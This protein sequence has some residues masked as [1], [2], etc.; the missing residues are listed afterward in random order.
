MGQGLNAPVRVAD[1]LFP[2]P[3]FNSDNRKDDYE[4]D[5]IL[6]DCCFIA[7]GGFRLRFRSGTA[8]DA[9]VPAEHLADGSARLLLRLG[10]RFRS[11]RHRIDRRGSAD[12]NLS[13][14]GRHAS[15]R[16]ARPH[17]SE[18]LFRRRRESRR[19]GRER[20][21]RRGGERNLQ[22]DGDGFRVRRRRRRSRFRQ[23]RRGEHQAESFRRHG[24]FGLGN[25]DA[26]DSKRRATGNDCVLPPCSRR[27]RLRW[28]RAP[29]G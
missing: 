14:G 4:K 2:F 16:P 25:G 9:D 20:Q 17:G 5:S 3:A 29:R 23:C 19:Q 28:A 1:S 11:A 6:I 15:R 26:D 27:S 13:H 21:K 18:S 24:L 22:P 8:G 7:R 12:G 10:A